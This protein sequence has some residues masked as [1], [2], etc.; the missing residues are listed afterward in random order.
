M[1]LQII[2]KETLLQPSKPTLRF[3]D[4][5][6]L[7]D[8]VRSVPDGRGGIVSEFIGTDDFNVAFYNRQRY[9]LDAGRDLE[10]ILYDRLYSITQDPTLPRNVP[11]YR[12]GPAGVVF[13]EVTEGGEVKFA[14][15]GQSNFSVPIKHYAFGLEYSKDLVVYNE[16]WSLAEVERQAGTAFNALLNHVHLYPILSYAYGAANQTAAA[17]VGS[18]VAEKTLRT[19]EDAIVAG[20]DDTS[21]P[22]RGPYVILCSTANV[23]TLERALTVVP[24]QGVTLQSSAIN[25]I[26]GIVAYNG[27]TG[28]RGNIST[29]YTGVT[30]NKAYLVDIGRRE[31]N[32]RSYVKQPLQSVTGNPDISR[33]ILEQTVWDTYFGIY[34]DVAAAVEEVALPTS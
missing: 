27:W 23:F 22:R 29:T 9:E 15:V 4:G 1:T 19:L 7:S 2:T 34:A 21:N 3:K 20:I 18:T 17:S 16:L 30:A 5:F 6:K 13:E 26:Q 8:H 24:Q 31:R 10:P 28:T 14:T 32:F 12:L 25:L 11:V 33:F